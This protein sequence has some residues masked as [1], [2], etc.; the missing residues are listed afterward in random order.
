MASWKLSFLAPPG[1]ALPFQGCA[2]YSRGVGAPLRAEGERPRH[3]QPA[4]VADSES[5]CRR[6]PGVLLQ[7][8]DARPKAWA[9]AESLGLGLHLKSLSL[10]LGAGLGLT[11][12]LI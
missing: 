8:V 10:G 2:S 9:W 7:A 5:G 4:S 6:V 3:G 11:L 1:T 12:T